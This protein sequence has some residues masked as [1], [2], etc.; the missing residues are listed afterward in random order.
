MLTLYALYRN[1]QP[2]LLKQS[3]YA[4]TMSGTITLFFEL[5]DAEAAK[6]EQL[7]LQET[8]QRLADHYAGAVHK[9]STITRTDITIKEVKL[10]AR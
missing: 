2:I 10:P 8:K 3:P 6:A 5:A 4:S 9:I 7:K 1:G